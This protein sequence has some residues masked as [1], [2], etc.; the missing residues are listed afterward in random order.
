MNLRP[1]IL[2]TNDDGIDSQ[3]IESLKKIMDKFGNTFIVAP[4]RQR[5]AESNSLTINNPLRVKEVRKND[6]F[7]GYSVDGTPSDC[8]KLALNA[9]IEEKIDLVVSGINHGKNT[10]INVLYS[11][12]VAGA[13]EGYIAG[14]PSIAFSVV[15]HD[16]IQDFTEVEVCIESITKQLLSRKD[17]VNSYLLNVNI[18]SNSKI[19]GVKIAKLSNSLWKDTFEKRADPFG[20]VYYW[21]SGAFKVNEQDPDTDD[22]WSNNNYAV[23]TP[24][25]IDFNNSEILH[26]FKFLEL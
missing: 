11:G 4:D 23:I 18:P 17:E 14:I 10:S 19:K 24:L 8:V 20:R 22:V 12:T 1:N 6:V 21:F 25:K 26:K 2:I 7:F 13:T 5:S 9:L 3:G 15:S 16:N